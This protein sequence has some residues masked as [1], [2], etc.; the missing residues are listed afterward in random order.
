MGQDR[1]PAGTGGAGARPGPRVR[2]RKLQHLPGPVGAEAQLQVRLADPHRRRRARAGGP[3]QSRVHRA[4][5]RAGQQGADGLDRRRRQ[6]RRSAAPDPRLRALSR[7]HG[8]DLQSTPRQLAAVLG[9][10]ALRARLLCDR[11]RRLGHV[12]PRRQP[13]RPQGQMPRRPWPP[14]AGREHRAD[15][16]AAD[17]GG[18]ACRLPLQRQQVWR[19]R[20]RQ[21]LD[22]P[23]PPV[24]GFPRAGQRRDRRPA[25][26]RARVHDGPVAQR[27][28][29]DREPSGECGGPAARPRAGAAGRPG[30]P[31]RVPT[32]QRRAHGAWR[33]CSGRSQPM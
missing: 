23:V 26:L 33:P 5:P 14:R 11:D 3:A 31:G 25:R 12:L 18:E 17:R 19:R 4:R 15:R 22:R 21:W 32:L 1:R 29:P 10:Q 16:G 6:L 20:S 27:H 7:Q 13:P 30:G 24:S 9:A 2:R 8:P 28:R